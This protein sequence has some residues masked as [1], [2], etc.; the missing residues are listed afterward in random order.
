MLYPFKLGPVYKQTIWG[1][2]NIK[3]H[4]GRKT[5]FDKVAESWD[6][7][8]RD[9][10]MN[11]VENGGLRGKTLKAVLDKYGE[12]ILGASSTGKYGERFPLL[13][14]IIDA[15][16]KLSV[17]VHPDDDFARKNGEANGKNEL[18]YIVAAKKGA[19][20]VW[21][22]KENITKEGF[23]EAVKDGTVEE[24]LHTVP[25]KPGDSFFIKAGTVHA[26]LDGILLMEIQQNSNTTYRIYDWG[27]VGKDG[28][29]RE[30]HVAKAIDAI[31]FGKP[32]TKDSQA[33]VVKKGDTQIQ[34]II[35]S[36]FFDIDKI[37]VESEYANTTHDSFLTVNV[38][39][40]TGKI[41]SDKFEEDLKAGDALL[42]PAY[43]GDYKISGK[44]K[45][46]Q[47]SV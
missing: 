13:I 16:D 39:E 33:S 45:F 12:K 24:T 20:L 21:G 38:I 5:P 31:H 29:P 27:R 28:K 41:T 32:L 11:I 44:I 47:T 36:K 26:I 1:G 2:T 7:T 10:G 15:A 37:A 6:V 19:K 8:C 42:L 9:D 18:W 17:Q 14:K 4:F 35:R 43:L 25:V 40:G 3:K 23:R 46:L 34:T 30:L 22:L